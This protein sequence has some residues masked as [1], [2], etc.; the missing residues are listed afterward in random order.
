MWAKVR[1][2]SGTAALKAAGAT[3][4]A[5][6]AAEPVGHKV[7]DGAK[8]AFEKAKPVA[9]KAV[10]KTSEGA[11][12]AWNATKGGTIRAVER[13]RALSGAPAP[14]ANVDSAEV[15]Q[16]TDNREV[17]PTPAQRDAEPAETV[18]EDPDIGEITASVEPEV[19]SDPKSEEEN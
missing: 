15:E 1:R 13:I 3:Q 2:A 8:T 9:E 6:K 4:A 19:I 7:A 11:S 14:E 17:T 18:R 12:V 10:V 5:Y 16:V